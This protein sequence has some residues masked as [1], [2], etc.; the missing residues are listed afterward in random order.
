MFPSIPCN[1]ASRLLAL[2][3]LHSYRTKS[4]FLPN[5]A[6]SPSAGVIEIV[7]VFRSQYVGVWDDNQSQVF[8]LSCSSSIN[9]IPKCYF[10]NLRLSTK[11]NLLLWFM[12]IRKNLL[13]PSRTNGTRGHTAHFCTEEARIS[14]HLSLIQKF[15]GRGKI[16]TTIARDRIQQIRLLV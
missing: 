4:I 5:P 14:N 2:W 15:S 13:Q 10:V 9:S 11:G 16:S 1:Q 12:W 6:W 8:V 7:S 3:N